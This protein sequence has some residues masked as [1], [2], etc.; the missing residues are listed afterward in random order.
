MEKGIKVWARGLKEYGLT[1]GTEKHCQLE[2][3]T[4]MRIGVKWPGGNTT[5][6]CSKGMKPY[7]KGWQII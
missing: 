2:G 6:P 3:C 7:R 4:G 1:T 5:W